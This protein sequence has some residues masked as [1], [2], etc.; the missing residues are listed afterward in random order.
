MLKTITPPKSA[1]PYATLWNDYKTLCIKYNQLIR[2][3]DMKEMEIQ[4]LESSIEELE[5]DL[6]ESGVYQH[7]D[8]N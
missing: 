5:A 6:Y 3:L 7:Y 8:F 2:Q 4:I 1:P